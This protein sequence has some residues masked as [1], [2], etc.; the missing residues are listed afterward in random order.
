MVEDKEIAVL[1][2]RRIIDEYNE[3]FIPYKTVIGT[4]N[5]FDHWFIADNGIAFPHMTEPIMSGICY[6][7]RYKLSEYSNNITKEKLLDIK[8]DLMAYSNMFIYKRNRDRSFY[9]LTFDKET[10]TEAVFYDKDTN[11]T[12]SQYDKYSLDEFDISENR[13]ILSYTPESLTNKVL[14]T[15]KGQDDAVKKIVTSVY[16]TKK[17]NNLTKRCMLIIGPTGCGKTEI[18]RTIQRLV[19]IPLTIFSIPGLSQ[20][21]YV[22]RSTEEILKQV[23]YDNEGDINLAE[24]SIVI[25]D[26]I[27]KLAYGETNRGDVSTSGVQNELLKIIEG[28]RRII[29]ISQD[30]EIEID[31]SN[32]LFIATGAFSELYNR[33]KENR[34]IGFIEETNSN[35]NLIN[36]ESLVKY[37]MKP[38]L[39]GRLPVVVELNSLTKE[40]I[41][42]ILINGK[43]SE[44]IKII[45][46]LKGKNIEITN[47]DELIDLIAENAIKQNI[48]ARG[49]I[50]TLTKMFD[51][52][53]YNI[54]SNIYKYDKLTIG[55]NIINDNKDY[56]LHVKEES[57]VR[58]LSKSSR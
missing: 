21:G 50:T 24:N 8:K 6:G 58:K 13:S 39:L 34:S 5:E 16:I 55:S 40:N 54:E 4:F 28:T 15:V 52:I 49:L 29:E 35:N 56:I 1:F 3:E 51:D 7:N 41:K 38:E 57:K 44:L 32:I 33:K 47:L 31:T 46:V 22:G 18:F 27:D 12:Y 43:E 25:L 53:F 45:D 9:V 36:N 11:Y 19:D 20:S 2:K 14:E 10:L 48:G 30:N 26:E 37:G 42:D 23:Y 17:Y